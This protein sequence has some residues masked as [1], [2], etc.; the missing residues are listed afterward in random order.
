MDVKKPVPNKRNPGVS[1]W[2]IDCMGDKFSVPLQVSA[3]IDA[4]SSPGDV[5]SGIR[6]VSQT[7][8]S[9]GGGIIGPDIDAE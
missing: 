5:A 2:L 7:V 4:V 8:L 3:K 1:L 6:T 9:G